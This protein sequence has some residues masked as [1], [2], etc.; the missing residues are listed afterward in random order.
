MLLHIS[1]DRRPDIHTIDKIIFRGFHED[2]NGSDRIFLGTQWI[3]G[4]WTIG[5]PEIHH[6]NFIFI[7]RLVQ[8]A[9][10][11]VRRERFSVIPETIAE[12]FR[13]LADAKG[14]RI[15]EGDLCYRPREDGKGNDLWICSYYKGEP[16]IRSCANPNLEVC[17]RLSVIADQ[18]EIVGNIYSHPEL[19]DLQIRKTEEL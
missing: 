15:F 14:N 9:T 2:P 7:G 3:K 12:A 17:Q 18:I 5:C 19:I 13:D 8:T 10:G 16:V 1:E 4:F 6:H 11:V